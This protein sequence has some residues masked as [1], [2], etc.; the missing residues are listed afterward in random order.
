MKSNSSSAVGLS[1]TRWLLL[2][3]ACRQPLWG[4]SRLCLLKPFP[5]MLWIALRPQFQSHAHPLTASLP[6]EAQTLLLALLQPLGWW[7]LQF[8]PKVCHLEQAVLLEVEASERLFG[9][10]HALLLQLHQASAAWCADTEGTGSIGSASGLAGVDGMGEIALS[11]RM[12]SAPTALAALALLKWGALRDCPPDRLSSVLDTLPPDLLDAAVPHLGTLQQL[13]CR[14]L[15][16]LRQL[17]RGGVSRRFGAGLLDA[18]DRAYGLKAETYPWVIL[19]EQFSVRLEFQGRIE[20]AEGMLFGV[21]RLL[22]QLKSWLTGRQKGVTAIVLR[23]EHDL[24]RR[25]EAGTG[26]LAVHTAQATRDMDHLVKLLAEHLARLQL[27]APVV[28]ISLEASGVEDMQLASSSLLPEDRQTGESLLMMVERLS[29]RLGADRVKTGALV[30]DHRPQRMQAWHAVRHEGPQDERHRACEPDA[31]AYVMPHLRPH[32]GPHAIPYAP[33]ASHPPWLL[34]EPLKL[35]MA[36]GLPLYQGPLKLLA[37]PERIEAGWW[38]LPANGKRTEGTQGAKYTQ[39]SENTKGIEGKEGHRGICPGT[40]PL[41]LRDYFIAQSE[42][43]G[44]VW[45]FRQ[46]R[47]EGP[48]RVAQATEWF[49]QGF[50]G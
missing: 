50:Y 5:S 49:L 19:P 32:V 36:G 8:S 38:D 34:R 46:R 48:T 37:G 7:A 1:I 13:G 40:D 42:H 28:A 23:W 18:L 2:A 11:L 26:A 43:A 22:L 31:K 20:V 33:Q 30:A 44:L 25:S 17:P 10:R 9:G 12:A 14:S 35:A 45:I 16:Q 4:T 3:P 39:G 21:K 29:A 6:P 24:Q 41:V 47:P 27:A 15:G